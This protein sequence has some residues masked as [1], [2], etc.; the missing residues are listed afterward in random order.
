MSFKSLK[1]TRKRDKDLPERAYDLAA[2]RRVIDGTLY[3]DLAHDFH[4]EKDGSGDYIP[5]RKRRPS[6]RFPVCRILAEDSISLLFS[7]DHWPDIHTDSEPVREALKK[8][9]PELGLNDLMLGAAL[10]G[11]VGSVA[12]FLRFLKGRVFV[13]YEPTEYL[14]PIWDATAPDT[15]LEVRRL[16]KMKGADLRPFGWSIPDEDLS[17]PHWVRIDWTTEREIIYTP[18]KVGSDDGPIASEENVTPHGLGFVPVVWIK[19]LPGGVAPDG[20][21]TFSP[22]MID[23]QIEID[24]LLSQAGRGLK[25]SM[26]PLLMI[27]EPVADETGTMVR[28][29][30]NA[31][32]VEEGGDVKLVEIDGGAINATVEYVRFLR[33]LALEAGHGNRASAEKLSAAQ[34]GRAMELMNQALIW[35]ADKLRVSYG[36]R[37]LLAIIRMIV[38][39]SRKIEI[40]TKSGEKIGKL[41]D[42]DLSL[43]WPHWYPPTYQDQ[44]NLATTLKTHADAGHISRETAVRTIAPV[45]DIANVEVEL[46]R[47]ESDRKTLLAEL[48]APQAK[49]AVTE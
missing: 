46:G 33:E 36:E 5:L 14:T 42:S 45:Y 27:K 12:I 8:L 34:S 49:I 32:Q 7:S 20:A 2:L 3:D 39:A 28:S 37:G 43:R 48:P 1:K 25:Y 16:Q 38:A 18:W 47:I 15:L 40:V 30:S 22:E 35:L 6:V 26:D 13:T 19:N 17:A 23:T 21:P 9:V 11:S 44:Q 29:A 41:D 4:D 10:C 31:I 24:Y